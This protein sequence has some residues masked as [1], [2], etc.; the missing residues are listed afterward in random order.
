MK[1]ISALKKSAAAIALA[2]GVTPMGVQALMADAKLVAYWPLNETPP[3][4]TAA[5]ALKKCNGTVT[6][7]VTFGP[8]G[9]TTD[10]PQ[11]N[12]E[13]IP[14]SGDF[15]GYPR[16]TKVAIFGTSA[17]GNNISV[18]DGGTCLGPK[19]IDTAAT[20]SISVWV[21]AASDNP[22]MTTTGTITGANLIE[23]S[24][25]QLMT[26]AAVNDNGVYSPI[27]YCVTGPATTPT[28]NG[29]LS[30]QTVCLKGKMSAYGESTDT[31]NPWHNLIVTYNKVPPLVNGVPQPQAVLYVDGIPV[32]KSEPPNPLLKHTAPFP[33]P[34]AGTSTIIGKKFRGKLDD[35][36]LYN[37]ALTPD[38]ITELAW[39][40]KPSAFD[41]K[42]GK[43]SIPCVVEEVNGETPKAYVVGAWTADLT[44]VPPVK[45]TTTIP[46][47]I[48]IPPPVGGEV[49]RNLVF[50]VATAKPIPVPVGTPAA[51]VAGLGPNGWNP[52][53]YPWGAFV[54]S[55]NNFD[56]AFVDEY[57]NVI[58]NL[59]CRNGLYIPA[60]T[61]P[62]PFGPST[63]D[64]YGAYLCY[65]VNNNRFTINYQSVRLRNTNCGIGMV[66]WNRE[67]NSD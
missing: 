23:R 4:T 61:V 34:Q 3:M 48:Y 65:A 26:G 44:A 37:V 42:T 24:G 63:K 52:S 8:T 38:D 25:L 7:T 59:E 5:D 60:V 1:N 15:I 39:G 36:R 58:D 46:G 13:A 33:Q 19:S 30:S 50:N 53:E 47:I 28:S 41:P 49:N 17:E 9:A 21:K 2:L 32:A 22:A 57:I 14:D 54:A 43:V 20:Y 31:N 55:Y 67:F 35:V 62:S 11:S 18:A 45:V 66:D 16:W 40:C 51:M 10:P 64:C 6:G 29:V 27:S 12:Y 56:T